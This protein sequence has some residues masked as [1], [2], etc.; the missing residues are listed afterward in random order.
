MKRRSKEDA[1][2]EALA[3]VRASFKDGD[4]ALSYLL[5]MFSTNELDIIIHQLKENPP[6]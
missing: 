4:S 5:E 3:I 2:A 6:K 1:V